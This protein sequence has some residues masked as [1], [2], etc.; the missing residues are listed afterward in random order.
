MTI[1][2]LLAD[3]PPPSSPDYSARATLLGKQWP[4]CWAV[5]NVFF[6]P[7]STLGFLSYLYSA[8]VSY[9]NA[10]AIGDYRLFALCAVSNLIGIVHSAVNMQP[11]ND[12]LASLDVTS[13]EAKRAGIMSVKS[14]LKDGEA[15]LRK[16]GNWNLV[17]VV[18]PLVSGTVALS[19]FI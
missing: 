3:F 8:I 9:N 15:I 11:L 4:H 13:P 17:R 18:V 16:W 2:A 10:S 1:P 7:I 19:Q 6:R 5:G 14:Q 12:K